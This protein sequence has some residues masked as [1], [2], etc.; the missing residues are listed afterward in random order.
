MNLAAFL[1]CVYLF[2][3][4]CG[5]KP[6]IY[7]SRRARNVGGI[8]RHSPESRAERNVIIAVILLRERRYT[9]FILHTRIK[10][11]ALLHKPLTAYVHCN[12]ALG[13]VGVVGVA[14]HHTAVGL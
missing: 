10:R 7:A 12:L 3:L 9:P 13:Q 8:L 11:I 6:V 4:V 5:V 1:A 14:G 2:F